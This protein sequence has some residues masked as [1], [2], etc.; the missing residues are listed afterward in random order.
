MTPAVS[1]KTISKRLL[2]QLAR[3]HPLTVLQQPHH[4][5]RWERQQQ[6]QGA[7]VPLRTVLLCPLPLA[8]AAR[9]QQQHQE[10]L[11]H[12]Q[13]QR[14]QAGVSSQAVALAAVGS[15]TLQRALCRCRVWLCGGLTALQKTGRRA[16]YLLPMRWHQKPAGPAAL[17]LSTVLLQRGELQ[18]A[19]SSS[20]SSTRRRSSR[21]SRVSAGLWVGLPPS[22]LRSCQPTCGRG[23]L[24]RLLL[25][26]LSFHQV[27]QQQVAVVAAGHRWC[28]QCLRVQL[29]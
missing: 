6:Q 29:G 18:V 13:E 9:L 24:L 27:Q 25:L 2:P 16:L 19:R 5:P 26:L 10:Q 23:H 15:R 11:Q 17:E 28:Q 3:G 14:Q 1:M 22:W 21:N 12:Q 8:L 7:L 4:T 20:S